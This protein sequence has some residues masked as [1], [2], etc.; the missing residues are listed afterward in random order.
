MSSI[1]FVLVN[2]KARQSTD[3]SSPTPRG[4]AEHVELE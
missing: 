2:S 1:A 3:L 4:K